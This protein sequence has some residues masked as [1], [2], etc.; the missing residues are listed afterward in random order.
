MKKIKA[1]I[2]NKTL[3]WEDG[4][5]SG[6][7]TLVRKARVIVAE[8]TI[9]EEPGIKPIP[10]NEVSVMDARVATVVFIVLAWE[11]DTVLVEAPE[12]VV[13]LFN[14]FVKEPQQGVIH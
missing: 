1:T 8:N 3:I 9:F 2:G 14:D 4:L 13:D 12:E 5:F 10:V 7:D 6:D 11:E